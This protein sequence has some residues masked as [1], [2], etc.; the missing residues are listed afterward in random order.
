M[1][2]KIH[3]QGMN[4]PESFR[5]T[6][7]DVVASHAAARR[8]SRIRFGLMLGV[9]GGAMVMNS[10]AGVIRT[11]A[12]WESMDLGAR[13]YTVLW[14][15][16]LVGATV[17]A[18]WGAHECLLNREPDHPA[19][20]AFTFLAIWT[21]QLGGNPLDVIPL[22]LSAG[23]RVGPG[24]VHLNLLGVILLMWHRWM[25]GDPPPSRLASTPSAT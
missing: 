21:L 19:V 14:L 8:A 20:R 3:G 1:D 7:D 5:D 2:S 11:V 18:L 15:L 17:T 4:H 10:G 12:T 24:A 9:L 25:F 13:I 23:L 6:L 22:S 16:I